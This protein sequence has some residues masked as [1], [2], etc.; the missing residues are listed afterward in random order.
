MTRPAATQRSKARADLRAPGLPGEAPVD[1]SDVPPAI[2]RAFGMAAFA[3]NRF[4]VDQTLRAARQ[5]DNDIEAM[6]L[7]GVLAHLNV[8]HLMPPGTRPSQALN[9]QGRLPDLPGRMR[10]IRLRDLC[11]ITGRP[12]ETVRR[13]LLQLQA[14]GRVRRLAAGYVYDAACVDAPMR[15]LATDGVRRFLATAEQIGAL[16]RDAEQ[17]LGPASARPRSR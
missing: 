9:A 7:F 2:P 15:E 6:T 10:P 16:L 17:A 5:F 4:I 13:K 8:A 14:Q 1:R 12:R 11:Q 3:M